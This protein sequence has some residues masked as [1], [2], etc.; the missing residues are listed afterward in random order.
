M[1][2]TVNCRYKNIIYSITNAADSNE[3]IALKLDLYFNTVH[4]TSYQTGGKSYLLDLTLRESRM[5]LYHQCR[6]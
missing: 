4:V 1:Y 3:V 5:C 6:K 2:D